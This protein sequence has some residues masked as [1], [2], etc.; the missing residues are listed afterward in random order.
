MDNKRK[1]FYN[2]IFL[3]FSFSEAFLKKEDFIFF[4]AFPHSIVIIMW[5]AQEGLKIFFMIFILFF[6]SSLYFSS[7]SILSIP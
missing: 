7:S 3:C 4:H 2:L 6:S 1:T 5:K